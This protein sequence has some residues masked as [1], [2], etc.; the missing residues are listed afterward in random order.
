MVFG[1]NRILC[2]FIAQSTD[3]SFSVSAGGGQ[4]RF[5]VVFAAKYKF[6]VTSELS[7]SC[8]DW[9]SDQ[10]IITPEWSVL[11]DWKIYKIENGYLVFDC[12]KSGFTHCWTQ[13]SDQHK[14]RIVSTHCHTE[15]DRALCRMVHFETGS[16]LP[17]IAGTVVNLISSS[18]HHEKFLL[19]VAI[20]FRMI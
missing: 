1:L 4:M 6:W 13:F 10:S 5:V 7:H 9:A 8:S 3:G 16:E 18:F 17:Q 14:C 19:V 12:I 2:K 11:T 20:N 15:I